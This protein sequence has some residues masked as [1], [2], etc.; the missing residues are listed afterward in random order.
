MVDYSRFMNISRYSNWAFDISEHFE[1]LI[2]PTGVLCTEEM[3][4]DN[5]EPS[6]RIAW[7][8]SIG[9]YEQVEKEFDF[10]KSREFIK[11]LQDTI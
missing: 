10:F 5:E 9:A 2:T 7:L 3:C 4:P 8:L 6:K 1:F 11:W